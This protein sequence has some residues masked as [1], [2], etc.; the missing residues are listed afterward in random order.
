M[1]NNKILFELTSGI[2]TA[3]HLRV[4]C[5]C[6]YDNLFNELTRLLKNG[7]I[8]FCYGEFEIIHYRLVEIS[9]CIVMPAS[10]WVEL[11]ENYTFF[12]FGKLSER[13][14]A[15]HIDAIVL[16]TSKESLRSLLIIDSTSKNSPHSFCGSA[17]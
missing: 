14:N 10:N 4:A 6:D 1:I 15:N 13:K 8:E 11:P 16:I 17:G 9:N 5:K 3:E 2:K 12:R 7:C